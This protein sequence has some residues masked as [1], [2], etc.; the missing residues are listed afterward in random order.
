MV[1]KHD[2][3]HV[4]SAYLSSHQNQ[5]W[6]WPDEAKKPIKSVS[7]K[8]ELTQDMISKFWSSFVMHLELSVLILFEFVAFLVFTDLTVLDRF[9][10]LVGLAEESPVFLRFTILRDINC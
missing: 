3:R 7:H 9:C 6:V 8:K 10:F 4:L 5:F 1:Y 2:P